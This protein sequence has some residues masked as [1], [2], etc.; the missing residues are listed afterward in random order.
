MNVLNV[1]ELERELSILAAR[2]RYPEIKRWVNTVARNYFLGQLPEKD[3][4]ANY[5]LVTLDSDKATDL[6]YRVENA[7]KLPSWASDAL[8][9]G[10]QLFWFDTVGT[11]RREVWK[12]LEIIL[13]WFNNFK[14]TDTRLSRLDRISFPVA[15]NAAAL[16]YKDISE[17]IWNYVTDKPVVVKEYDH[18]YRWV[19][20][21]SALQFEREGQI[22]QMC[23][24]NGSYYDRWRKQGLYEY[25]SLRDS[26][27]QPHVTL[28]INYSHSHPDIRKGS[29]IQ[30]KG[31]G[32]R[33]PDKICQ[34][35]I[36]RF[37]DDMKFEINGDAHNIDA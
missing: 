11:R 25:L 14:K 16:W 15:T 3:V 19:K 36:R 32:N 1:P 34:P 4:T 6:S 35:Y 17:N 28:E 20:L 8:V 10:D 2:A 18:G 7:E 12:V 30:C 21:V 27:N 37:I 13:I 23:V 9:R 24:G 33:K 5:R 31:K 26:K 29:L 22:M